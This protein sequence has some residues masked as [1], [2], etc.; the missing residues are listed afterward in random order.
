MRLCS[1]WC[2]H[3]SSETDLE[4]DLDE[5]DLNI[6]KHLR[7]TAISLVPLFGLRFRGYSPKIWANFLRFARENAQRGSANFCNRSNLKRISRGTKLAFDRDRSER[8]G[9]RSHLWED[10]GEDGLCRIARQSACISFSRE[11]FEA[12]ATPSCLSE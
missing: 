4:V 6:G 12:A 7:P 5:V 8:A 1:T 10:Q 9:A 11:A 3:F 2:A